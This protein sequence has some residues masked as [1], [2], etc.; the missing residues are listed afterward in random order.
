MPIQQLQRLL[1]E[2]VAAIPLGIVWPRSL[3]T[4]PFADMV[5]GRSKKGA[6][7]NLLGIPDY[8]FRKAGRSPK[9]VGACLRLHRAKVLRRKHLCARVSTATRPL[10]S[11]R[12][13]VSSTLGM[14]PRVPWLNAWVPSTKE[15]RCFSAQKQASFAIRRPE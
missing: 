9:W 11:K 7:A 2:R 13:S 14:S 12:L 8:R 6:R 4:G 3:G 5:F 10:G 15:R 1:A